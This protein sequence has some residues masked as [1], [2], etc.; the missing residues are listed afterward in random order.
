[1]GAGGNAGDTRGSR[2]MV[3]PVNLLF[4]IVLALLLLWLAWCFILTL[5][6]S[7]ARKRRALVSAQS[8]TVDQL[9]T[10]LASAFT[11]SRG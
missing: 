1:M 10:T 2:I 4:G 6:A 9:I 8:Q 7:G 5:A 3:S 11:D